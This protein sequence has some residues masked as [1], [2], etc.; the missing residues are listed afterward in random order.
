MSALTTT[1]RGYGHRHQE[2]RALWAPEVAKGSTRCARCRQLI[3]PSE[4]WDLGHADGDRSRYSGP[5]HRRCNRATSSRR[6][7]EWSKAPPEPE[8]ERSGLEADD[9]RWDMP[10]LKG[11][12]K[13]PKDAVWPRL[14]TV[15]HP[16][17]V[18]SLGRE[19]VRFAE[20]RS[21]R[22][23]RWWQ[24]L[25]ATRLLEVDGQGE[26]VWETAVLIDGPPAR[27]VLAAP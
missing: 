4:P 8:P 26:L 16:L 22:P 5:E 13:I 6:A 10:W 14:M 7:F 21:G 12:R 3:R 11:L 9:E 15:P 23:L 24:K 25:A 18:G 20:K 2:R 17:A 27:Q 19:F 1:E